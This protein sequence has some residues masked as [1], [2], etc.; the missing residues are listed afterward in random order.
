MVSPIHIPAKLNNIMLTYLCNVDPL[1]P[2]F[3]IVKLGFTSVYFISLVSLL[4][5]D[6]GYSLEPPH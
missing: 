2:H 4:N 3:Y 5:I 6:G 1:T